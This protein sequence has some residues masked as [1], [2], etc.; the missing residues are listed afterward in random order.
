[1]ARMEILARLIAPNERA[2]PYEARHHD[3]AANLAAG[4]GRWRRA[5]PRRR[6][7]ARRGAKR[8]DPIA[9]T[10]CATRE[11]GRSAGDPA[12]TAANGTLPGESG[13]TAKP[14]PPA[15]ATSARTL[16]VATEPGKSREAL[17]AG[18]AAA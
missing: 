10:E 15:V 5:D 4:M 2:T 9:T 1:M 13:M 3:P 12:G 8:R 16:N 18:V 7:L 17:I 11:Q 14:K 6:P